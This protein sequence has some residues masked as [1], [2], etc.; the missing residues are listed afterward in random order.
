MSFLHSQIVTGRRLVVEMGNAQHRRS[1]RVTGLTPGATYY[2]SVQA[3]DNGFAGSPFAPE[4]SFS[5]VG[6]A[7]AVRATRLGD[8][9]VLVFIGTPGAMYRIQA[10]SELDEPP[11]NIQWSQVGVRSASANGEFEFSVNA[12]AFARRFYRAAYP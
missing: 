11:A 2:W 3:V 4:Q 10:T 1:L 9:V 5:T 6:S 7:N 8:E 12:T